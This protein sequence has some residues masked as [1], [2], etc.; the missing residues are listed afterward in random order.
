MQAVLS[1]GDV[2]KVEHDLSEMGVSLSELMER[3]G[4]AAADEV[5]ALDDVEEVVVLCGTGNNGGDGWVAARE[6]L[7]A[8]LHPVVVT[9]I[10]PHEISSELACQAALAAEEAGV[11]YVV[12]PSQAAVDMLLLAC[13]VV[14]DCMLGTGFAGVPRTPLSL[15]IESANA[16]GAPIIA[17]DV[18]SGLSAQ[19]GHIEGPCIIAQ[20]TVSMLTLKPGLLSDAGRDVCGQIVVAPL[21]M[22]TDQLAQD[23]D[24]LAWRADLEDYQEV[25][26]IPTNTFDK[27]S[28]GSVLVVGGSARFPGA[29]M[30]AA[31]AA[32]R[33]GAGYV[34]LAVP[35][36]IAAIAQVRMLEIPV[37][38]LPAAEDGTFSVEAA[39]MVAEL[40]QNRTAVVVGP[41]MRVTEGAKAVVTALLETDVPLVVDADGLNCLAELAGGNVENAPE[42]LRRP[43][44]LVL[45]PH[46]GELAR[47]V[48]M[49][50]ETPD[51]LDTMLSAARRIV[52]SGGGSE[53]C[54][55]AKSNASACVGVGT[56]VLP[57]PGPAALATAGSGDV[58]SGI[59]GALLAQTTADLESLPLLASYACEIHGLAGAMA[60][61]DKGSR[62]V[63]ASDVIE[64]VGLAMDTFEEQVFSV[65][66]ED[67]DLVE[68]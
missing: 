40:A 65:D 63:M 36:S 7:A 59:A 4:S 6:L 28:R 41:G 26:E 54:V 12:D 13:D 20:E 19:T 16:C 61:Q 17:V 67:D 50:D 18:P 53:L 35:E 27:F 30:M 2:R 24:P 15:W 45:T 22:E 33:A 37:V 60:A 49:E 1:I 44:A 5:M 25:V 43:Q 9:P 10:E 3:A 8:G 55:V 56:A 23:M 68:E 14:L 31:L 42:L 52:W 51:S 47:L 58:L 38:A 48:G 29:P 21:A 39:H 32:A 46:R 11:E 66:F 64:R 57:K 62:G 34:T